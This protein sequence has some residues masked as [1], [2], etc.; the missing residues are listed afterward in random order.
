VRPERL[1]RLYP[2]AWRARYGE[3]FLSTV[4]RES[5]RPQQV[6]DIISGTI[7]AW[8]SADVWRAATA[9]RVA[10]GG[11]GPSMPKSLMICGRNQARY[12]TRDGL[13]GAGVML[14]ATLVFMALGI[15]ARRQG[16]TATGEVLVSLSFPGSMMLSMPFWLM[17][18]QP[19]KA[20]LVIVGGT[21]TLLILIGYLS[22]LI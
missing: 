3:E 7:D 4:G 14:G 19:W 12:T 13:I 21:L 1:L 20:Q 11:G 18:G 2:R 16:W 8:L 15:A 22:T 10:P 9:S 17:K 5:L 6:I